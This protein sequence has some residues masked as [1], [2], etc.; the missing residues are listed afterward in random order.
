M[1]PTIA[2]SPF[3]RRQTPESRFSHFAGTWEDLLAMV[4]ANFDRA[5]PGYRSDVC[6]VPVDPKGFFSGTVLLQDGDK[7]AG[8]YAPRQPGEQPRKQTGVVG[9]QKIPAKRVQIVLY[10]HAVLAENDEQSCDA[11]WEIISVNATPTDEDEPMPVG[12]LLHNHF[13]VAGS[14]DGGTTTGMSDAEF[15]AALRKSFD[16]WKD[17]GT[18]WP[19]KAVVF[20]QP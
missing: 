9:G 11:D 12:T 16:Y 13:H 10:A 1:K 18:V 19:G 5:V 4:E 7:F 8:V 20:H 6:L 14:N 15:I 3:V 17:K 2:V